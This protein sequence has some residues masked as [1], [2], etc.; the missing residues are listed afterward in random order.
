MA[1]D[2]MD[3]ELN[4]LVELMNKA[5]INVKDDLARREEVWDIPE[6]IPQQNF[7]PAELKRLQDLNDKY[8]DTNAEGIKKMEEAV[9]WKSKKT[10][11]KVEDTVIRSQI[12][13]LHT[14][15][16]KSDI[17]HFKYS[18]TKF[19]G[20]AFRYRDHFKKDSDI[21]IEV[22]K[23]RFFNNKLEIMK[24]D[25]S[26]ETRPETQE[27]IK[28]Q[29]ARLEEAKEDYGRMSAAWEELW[30]GTYIDDEYYHEEYRNDIKEAYFTLR[31]LEE[32]YNKYKNG[33]A[34]EKLE[35]FREYLG[36]AQDHT[37]EE[38]YDSYGFSEPDKKSLRVLEEKIVQERLDEAN[39][40]G[41]GEVAKRN[42]ERNMAEAGKEIKGRSS[43]ERDGR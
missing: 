31:K 30:Q 8:F 3:F 24:K 17:P 12:D 13:L 4:E 43:S 10:D 33:M 5:R 25:L 1:L 20:N 39:S 14:S 21:R 32:K 40:K 22:E 27:Q 11:Y 36:L 19:C 7:S 28:T 34:L 41:S 23:G 37:I 26:E 16:K 38:K 29:I 2:T 6:E 42:G 9:L 35:K 15:K 18:W